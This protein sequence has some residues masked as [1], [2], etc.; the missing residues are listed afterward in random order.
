MP[1]AKRRVQLAANQS[2]AQPA[3]GGAQ[4]GPEIDPI[5]QPGL[6]GSFGLDCMGMLPASKRPA[7]LDI[8][9]SAARF[10]I[11]VLG[12]PMLPKGAARHFD[13][14]SRAFADSAPVVEQPDALP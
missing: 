10:D 1:I 12:G 6:S 2:A 8:A 4:G 7:D 9:E 11:A 14:R 13:F 5:L 3:A